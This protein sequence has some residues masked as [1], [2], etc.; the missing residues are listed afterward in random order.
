MPRPLI[1]EKDFVAETRHLGHVYSI[2][3]ARGGPTTNALPI[4]ECLLSE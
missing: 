1:L 4:T 2:Q 3:N